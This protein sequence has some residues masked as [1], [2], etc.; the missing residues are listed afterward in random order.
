M[1]KQRT[2]C[3]NAD[4]HR[5]AQTKY[6]KKNPAAQRERV[7]KTYEKNKSKIKAQK[8]RARTGGQKKGGPKGR[9]R[10]C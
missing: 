2:V 10:K 5:K 4:S 6:V 3:E 9:P 8:K 1:A 7:K